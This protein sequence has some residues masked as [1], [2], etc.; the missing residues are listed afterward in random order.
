V[1]ALGRD[2][3]HNFGTRRSVT[4]VKRITF[5]GSGNGCQIRTQRRDE[6]RR[7][8]IEGRRGKKSYRST[9][10]VREGEE[11]TAKEP[12]SNSK[13]NFLIYEA[14]GEARRTATHEKENCLPM[15]VCLCGA[16][17]ECSIYQKGEEE[18]RE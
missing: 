17:N 1:L 18:G 13:E 6:C 14:R 7:Q 16:G 15:S 12:A 8:E 4:E 2:L 3:A 11:G 9:L 10:L 5:E